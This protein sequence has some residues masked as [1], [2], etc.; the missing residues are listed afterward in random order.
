VT[1]VASPRLKPRPDVIRVTPAWV[2]Y[3]PSGTAPACLPHDRPAASRHRKATA[4][5]RLVT[6]RHCHRTPAWQEAD[7]FAGL[8]AYRVRRPS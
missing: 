1:A 6:C 2:H 8:D 3:V 5:P 7:L 4:D